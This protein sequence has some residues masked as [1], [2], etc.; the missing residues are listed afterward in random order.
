[1]MI[2]SFLMIMECIGGVKYNNKSFNFNSVSF[3]HICY[4]AY[5]PDSFL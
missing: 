4:S 1:M 3:L 2:L 5:I